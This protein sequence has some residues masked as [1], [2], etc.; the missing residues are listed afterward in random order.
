M[1]SLDASP[2][3]PVSLDQGYGSGAQLDR[4]DPQPV[5]ARRAEYDETRG[6]SSVRGAQYGG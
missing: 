2:R 5:P 1:R 3:G 4:V 6:E